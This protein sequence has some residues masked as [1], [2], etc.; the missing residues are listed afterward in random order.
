MHGD[1]KLVG[2]NLQEPILE[3]PHCELERYGDSKFKSVCPKCKRGLLGVHRSNQPPYKLQEHDHC[4]LCGQRVR[5]LDI[6][7]LR[8]KEK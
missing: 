6:N 7:L 8:A 2:K 4:M 5:Y 3:I 1:D